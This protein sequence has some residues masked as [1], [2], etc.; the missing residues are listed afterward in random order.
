MRPQLMLS[1]YIFLTALFAALLAVPALR[2]W[3]LG[4]GSLD[5]PDEERKVHS[6]ATPRLGGVAIF[7]AFLFAMLMFKEFNLQVR[8]LMAGGLII[9]VTGLADDLVG[10]SPGRK[11]AG[12]IL[13]CLVTMTVGD[14]YLSNLGD[15]FGFGEIVLPLWLAIPFTVFAVVGMINAVNLIDGLDGLAGGVTVIALATF[16]VLDL[17]A[18]S[19]ECMI[20]CA[21]L[22]GGVLGFLKYNVYP[23]RIFMGDVGSLLVGFL[24]GFLAIQLTQN[25]G[26]SIS[27]MVP[28]LVLGVPIIDTVWVMTQRMLCGGSPF[29]ADRTHLHHKFLDLGVQHRFTVLIIYGLSLFGAVCALQLHEQPEYLLLAGYL[30]V[31]GLFYLALRFVLRHRDR[32]PLLQRD[33]QAGLKQTAAYRRMQDLADL[34]VNG[35]KALVGLLL[36]LAVLAGG[37]ASTQEAIFALAVVG[38]G[39]VLVWLTRDPGNHF[40]HGFLY[41]AGLV[42]IVL[43]EQAGGHRIVGEL[44]VARAG[45]I[46]YGLMAPLVVV[47]IIF[48][49]PQEIYLSTPFDFLILAMSL[50]LVIVSPEVTLAYNLPWIVGKAVLLFLALKIVAISARSYANQV[51]GAML[52]ALVIVV[53]RGLG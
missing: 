10:L 20:L 34:A 46:L 15:L 48:K 26:Q 6:Q 18:G 27:P 5:L 23:A 49:R 38:S 50:S 36:L 9:F 21:A 8:A 17:H 37:R 31:S 51:C 14:L 41:L 40:F 11:F 32:F 1:F 44:D 28:V 16:F 22:L 4:T 3:A 19:G 52:A 33:S 25:P 24:L 12:Q 29:V 39:A 45:L 30:A 53:V 42:L 13:A 43:L 47:K 2:R 7:L 35:L